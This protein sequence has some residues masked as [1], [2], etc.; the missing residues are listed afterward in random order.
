MQILLFLQW[1]EGRGMQIPL[2]LQWFDERGG[3][4]PLFL[5]RFESRGC[6]NR[7]FCNVLRSEACKSHCFYNDLK[8][9]GCKYQCF[10]N[11]LR[12]GGCKYRGFYNNYHFALLLAYSKKRWAAT[13][14]ETSKC[15][16]E[17]I[18]FLTIH[19]RLYYFMGLWRIQATLEDASA[20]I[21][22][23]DLRVEGCKYRCFY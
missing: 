18:R 21:F 8:S 17:N 20:I 22:Y 4:I 11:D 1:F 13:K 15:D 16:K 3:Q 14:Q 12:S 5:Q 10:Y 9:G 2:F 19:F 6:K 7:C 23:N